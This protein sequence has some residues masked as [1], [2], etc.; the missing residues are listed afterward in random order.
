[1]RSEVLLQGVRVVEPLE[2]KGFNNSVPL[3]RPLEPDPLNRLYGD[4]WED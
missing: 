1:M 2:P 3:N 4:L